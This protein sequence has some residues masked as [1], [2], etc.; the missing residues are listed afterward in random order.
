MSPSAIFLIS[1]VLL[2]SICRFIPPPS[3]LLKRFDL[4]HRVYGNVVDKKT[5]Q[6]LLRP[7]AWEAVKRLRQ[8]IIDGCISDPSGVPLYFETGKDPETGA[9]QYRCVR[10]T[11]DLEGYHLHMRMLMSW[12]VSPRL[13]NGILLEHNYQW[14]MRQGDKNRR[15]DTAVAGFFDQPVIEAI[16]VLRFTGHKNS[17]SG[18][19]F[20]F[21]P[22]SLCIFLMLSGRRVSS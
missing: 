17:L 9:P 20:P 11:N 7:E 5:K 14:N 2:F 12:V 8:H 18:F 1:C 3:E 6:P 15:F 22:V 13:A 21:F 4:V 10:G 16:Q 19:L